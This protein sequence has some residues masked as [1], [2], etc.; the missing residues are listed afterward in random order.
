MADA[1]R[2]RMAKVRTATQPRQINATNGRVFPAFQG[3]TCQICQLRGMTT[4]VLDK[5]VRKA[6]ITIKEREP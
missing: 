3:S 2:S 1:D 6:H 4:R 5:P